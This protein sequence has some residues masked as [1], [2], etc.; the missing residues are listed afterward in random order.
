[1]S[2]NVGTHIQ[3]GFLRPVL[4]ISQP[5]DPTIIFLYIPE[6]RQALGSFVG[7]ECRPT[8]RPIRLNH[9]RFFDFLGAL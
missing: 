4:N 3:I 2:E 9:G 1:M 7:R 5:E 8:I 6:R